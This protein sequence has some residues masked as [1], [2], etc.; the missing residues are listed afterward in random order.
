MSLK[1]LTKY[2]DSHPIIRPL[3]RRNRTLIIVS[4]SKGKRLEN[5]VQGSYPENEIVWIAKG[6][7][8]SFQ[9]AQFIKENVAHFVH[10]FG[11]ILLV[12]WTGTCD[13]TH[14]IQQSN[15]GYRFHAQRRRYIDLNN[16]QIGDILCQY[17]EILY[18]TSVYGSAVQT[19]FLECPQYSIEIWNENH[20]HPNVEIFQ[21]N[22]K[23]LQLKIEEL[24]RA[25]QDLNRSN[26]VSAPKFGLD[27]VKSRK[28]NKSYT[29]AKISYSL[30]EDGIHPDIVL[31]Q[32]WLRRI[33]LHLLVPY[34]HD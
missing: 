24:N 17:Q 23:T 26:N 27:L 2:I 30:L 1:D 7:R 5:C 12:V 4:D 11:N 16:I 15:Y 3:N 6:G 18:C 9:A 19:I 25:I 21:S 31:S 29:S 13:L 33:V 22:N 32:Y 8:N 10:R 14:F 34:C 28:S 20:H